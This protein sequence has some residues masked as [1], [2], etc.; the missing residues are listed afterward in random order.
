MISN[1]RTLAS[2]ALL[3]VVIASNGASARSSGHPG[4][5]GRDNGAGRCN[6]CHS[7]DQYD[8]AD[9]VLDDQYRKDCYVKDGETWMLD[10]SFFVVPYGSELTVTLRATIPADGSPD[11]PNTPEN[12][13]VIGLYCP[14]GTTCNAPVAGFAIEVEGIAA[15]PEGGAVLEASDQGTKQAGAVVS[16]DPLIA[17]PGSRIEVNHSTPR[18]FSGEEVSWT[19]TLHTPPLTPNPTQQIRLWAGVNACN[20][21]GAADLGD[22]T[23]YTNRYVYFEA[24]N[25]GST[26]PAMECTVAPTCVDGRVLNA[27]LDCA[28]PDGQIV[29]DGVCAEDPGSCGCDATGQGD[30]RAAL[31]AL[32]GLL[33]LG[34]RRRR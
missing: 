30:P 6:R 16:A 1:V 10:Q 22:I 20:G 11:N 9:I 8:G 31:A 14:E 17:D 2:L 32:I 25:G 7:P 12:D 34:V 29:V 27:D 24:A 26:A 3:S 5:T 28:C 4:A 19:M 15:P 33:A 18:A 23:S 13:R 21:N